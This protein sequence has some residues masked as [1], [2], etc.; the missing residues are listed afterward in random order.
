M[1]INNREKK[2]ILI[3]FIIAIVALPYFFLI[4]PYNEKYTK[5]E[6]EIEKLEERLA[7]LMELKEQEGFYLTEIDRLNSERETIISG[8]A[9][10]I[11]QE[12]VIMFLRGL[13]L[14]IPVK[15]ETISF[16][17]NVITP[18]SAG[19]AGEDGTVTG[20]ID[21]VKTQTSVAY[22]CDYKSMKALLEYVLKSKERMVISTVDMK[23]DDA[24]GLLE[25]LFVIDQ[26]AITGDGRELAPATIPSMMHGNTSV[27]GTYISDEEYLEKLA[28][29]AEKAAEAETE[30][31]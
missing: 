16:T 10:G 1:K 4:K 13:E 22:K 5:A 20:A 8:Y 21:A 15:M 3:I 24:T 18:I 17:G 31:D 9:K 2:I 26:Y 28:E 11:R 23:Y 12:N 6:G 19:T 25:G 14:N 29:E 30:E 27:F 7:Y